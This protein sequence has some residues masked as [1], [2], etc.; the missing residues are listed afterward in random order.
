[1]GLSR[2]FVLQLCYLACVCFIFQ[3]GELHYS[4]VFF[5]FALVFVVVIVCLCGGDD[6]EC[7]FVTLFVASG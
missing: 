6:L 7:E 1:M 5:S 2:G 3:T 4:I